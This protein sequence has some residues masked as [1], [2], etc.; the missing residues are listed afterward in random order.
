ML[1]LVGGG[2]PL[3]S[4]RNFHWRCGSPKTLQKK[5]IFKKQKFVLQRLSIFSSIEHSHTMVKFVLY[6][7]C[8]Q[9]QAVY[10]QFQ[11]LYVQ[12]KLLTGRTNFSHYAKFVLQ[13]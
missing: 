13:G 9:L 12:K 11:A 4:M 10:V 1:T 6:R 8:M 3:S 7:F 2:P 5:K